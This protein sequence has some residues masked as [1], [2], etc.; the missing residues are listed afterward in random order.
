MRTGMAFVNYY[1]KIYI[2]LTALGIFFDLAQV[3]IAQ[4]QI[5]PTALVQPPIRILNLHNLNL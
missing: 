3:E 5:R 4:V 2:S 1:V